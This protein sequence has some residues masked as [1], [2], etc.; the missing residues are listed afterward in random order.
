MQL[1]ITGLPSSEKGVIGLLLSLLWPPA[2]SVNPLVHESKDGCENT[3]RVEM[4]RQKKRMRFLTLS[5]VLSP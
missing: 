1:R 4:E 2:R 3:V 5:I